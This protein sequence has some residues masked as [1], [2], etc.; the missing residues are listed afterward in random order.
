M[1]RYRL[2]LKL[3]LGESDGVKSGVLEHAS[4]LGGNMV[5]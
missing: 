3:A 2:F 1:L 4:F 5:E